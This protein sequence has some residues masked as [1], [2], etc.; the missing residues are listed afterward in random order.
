MSG[1]AAQGLQRK[2]IITPGQL[3]TFNWILTH[4]RNAYLLYI[5]YLCYEYEKIRFGFSRSAIGHIGYML[6]RAGPV[7]RLGSVY[8]GDKK[9]WQQYS[10]LQRLQLM[11]QG[12]FP[13]IT[14]EVGSLLIFSLVLFYW[15]YIQYI[16]FS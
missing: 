10:D 2:Q 5:F 1:H 15:R 13:F 16:E 4:A 9:R 8:V 11:F 12:Y 6:V 7:F 3:Y 14:I